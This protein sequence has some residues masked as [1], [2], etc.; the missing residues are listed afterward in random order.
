M[1]IIEFKSKAKAECMA[2]YK[3]FKNKRE[4]YESK[5]LDKL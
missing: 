1:S 5:Y 2:Y 3:E 4:D